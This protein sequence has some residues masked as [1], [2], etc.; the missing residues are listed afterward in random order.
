[1]KN[2]LHLLTTDELKDIYLSTPSMKD[3]A[4]AELKNRGVSIVGDRF[5]KARFYRAN[6]IVP[7]MRDCGFRYWAS[8]K[9]SGNL[10]ASGICE[11]IK[12]APCGKNYFQVNG[13][14]LSEIVSLKEQ[15]D[16]FIAASAIGNGESTLIEHITYPNFRAFVK[17]ESERMGLNSG[18]EKWNLQ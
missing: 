7:F 13:E 14:G 9:S 15:V 11:F 8:L 2:N 16:V 6:Q 12:D 3:K 10:Y 18:L 17:A 4:A 5:T 1:M